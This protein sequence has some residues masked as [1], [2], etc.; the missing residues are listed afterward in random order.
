MKFQ[1]KL[2]S[3]HKEFVHISDLTTGR[4]FE[5][6]EIIKDEISI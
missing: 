2:G 6:Y 1:Y 3:N 4:D 5:L